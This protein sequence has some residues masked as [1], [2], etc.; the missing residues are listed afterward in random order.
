MKKL[1]L[2]FLLVALGLTNFAQKAHNLKSNLREHKAV[3]KMM[4]GIEP[5]KASSVV[6]SQ[7]TD[8]PAFLPQQKNVNIVN[9][10]DIGTSAN[11]YSYGYGGGQKA[12]VAAAPELNVV[13]NFHRMGGTLDPGGNSGDLGYDISFDGGLT[14]TNMIEIYVSEN[15]AGGSYYTDAARYP[16]HGIYNPEGNTDVANAWLQYHAP[17]LDGS[18]SPDSWGGYSYGAANLSD[19]QGTKTKNLQS[20]NPP[21]Y[22]YIIDAYDITRQGKVFAVDINQDWGSGTVV[23]QGSLI[24]NKGE[25]DEVEGDFVFTQELL[26]APV[27]AATTR[28]SNA[29]VAFAEDG[30][31][32]YI[33]FLGD[34]ETVDVISAAP[35]YYPVIFKT[36]DGGETW[37]GGQGIQ[38]GGPNGLAGIVNDLLT[39][40][41]IAELYEEPLPAR[42]EIPYT[43]AFDH[44]IAVDAN[45]NL[46]IAVVVGVVGSTNYSIVSASYLFAAYDIYTTDGGTTWHA[47]KLG[48]I[49]QFRGTW[50]G[51]YTEDN[52]I[53][54]SMS[55]D[56]STAFIL[57]LDTDL[58]SVEDNTR[59]NIYA[60]GVR[61]NP[62]GT[63]D[64]TCD[65]TNPI[66]TNVTLFSAGMWNA[67]FHAVAS[68]SLFADGKY[69]IPMTYQPL[70]PD[71]DP[72]TPVQYKYIT[73]FFY[74]DADFCV[75][76]TGEIQ[77]VDA[78]QVSQNFPN[79]FSNET[80]ISV[81]L[82]KGSQLNVEVFNLTGQKVMSRDLGYKPAGHT[83]FMLQ[84]ETLPTGVYFYTVQAG[85]EKI[86]RKMIVK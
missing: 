41:Q 31:T 1:S 84:A 28:P 80:N 56:R 34:N 59:P 73:N 81:S 55:P 6:H 66:P 32:G 21:V 63:A 27:A 3:E 40:D 77:A 47:V 60:R 54:I 13:T 53:Q 29:K 26:D 69:T 7:Q 19:P 38:L 64:L 10:I 65:G 76:G 52:R 16:S 71:V 79:P 35:G 4:V 45:G 42:D 75:V 82:S 58:E 18:N 14:W 39:D 67:T 68:M 50:P 36:T 86:T 23:Y 44:D 85:T 20:S 74:T 15:N 62:W 51:D 25:F 17:N 24:I 5:A 49:R 37:D 72:G 78:L 12:I 70:P 61:P 43:T 30:M 11:A 83:S 9:I 22:Q 48:S 33:T 46:H 8:A 57:W 2:L